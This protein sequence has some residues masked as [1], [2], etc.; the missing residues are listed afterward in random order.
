MITEYYRISHG[1][2]SRFDLC[3][4]VDIEELIGFKDLAASLLKDILDLSCED[5]FCFS[6][7]ERYYICQ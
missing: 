7:T 6:E 3:A 2:V 4:L 5:M 1:F